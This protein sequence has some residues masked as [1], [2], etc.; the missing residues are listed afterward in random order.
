ME[1]KSLN[2]ELRSKTGKGVC[3]RLREKGLVPAVVYGKGI[4]P[5]PVTVEP[6]ALAAAIAGEGGHNNLITLNGGEGLE[7]AVVIVADILRGSIRGE[8]RHVDLHKINLAENVHVEVPVSLK[9]TAAGV[10]EGGL[11]DFA[12]HNLEI[13]C[14]PTL[15]P[16]HIEVDVTELAIGHSIHVSELVLPEGVKVLADMKASV[17]SVL[18]RVKEEEAPAAEEK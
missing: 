17:V 6:K 8:F 12:M 10:K 11:L 3:R 7:G 5:V 13:E 2:I 4:E 14:L 1:R 16:E 9:G 18:G 15:I